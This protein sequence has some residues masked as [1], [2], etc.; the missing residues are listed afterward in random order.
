MF[1]IKQII[2]CALFAGSVLPTAALASTAI[3]NN[4]QLNIA[5]NDDYAW[6]DAFDQAHVQVSGGSISYLTLHN[7]ATANIESGDIS[8]L[9]LHNDTTAN[10]ESGDISWLMLH[11][12]STANI[13]NGIISWVKAYDRSFIRLTGAEDLSWLVFHSADSRAE[14]VANNVSYSN[15]HLSGNW[16]DGRVFSFWAIHQDLYNSSVMPTN[17]VITQVPEPSGLLLFAVGVPFAFLWSRQ[18]AKS[19]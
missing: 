8:Y 6:L 12:N 17:I 4:T 19:A 2:A 1:R 9:T 11:D 5:N 15:G 14:I 16:A 13:E 10:I 18:R 3:H 7:D